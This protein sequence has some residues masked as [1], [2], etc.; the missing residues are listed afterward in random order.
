MMTCNTNRREKCRLHW[1]TKD[2]VLSIKL[3]PGWTN[4]CRKFKLRYVFTPLLDA[5]C[6][7]LGAAGLFIYT[8]PYGFGWFSFRESL[9][10][11]Y[12]IF[13]TKAYVNNQIFITHYFIVSS[14]FIPHMVHFIS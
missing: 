14:T 11:N 4:Y 13:V 5:D 3:F 1:T 2:Y 10:G 12:I 9:V 6:R 8:T 7:P